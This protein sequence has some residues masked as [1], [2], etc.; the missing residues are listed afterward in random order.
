MIPTKDN[1]GVLIILKN[2]IEKSNKD[3][4]ESSRY[5]KKALQSYVLKEQ[6]LNKVINLGYAVFRFTFLDWTTF[7]NF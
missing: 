4:L 1:V 5:N 6:A 2:Y 3:Y 7:P